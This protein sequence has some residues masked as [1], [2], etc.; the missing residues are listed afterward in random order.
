MVETIEQIAAHEARLLPP[1][2]TPAQLAKAERR[3]RVLHEQ[4]LQD[5]AH[6]QALREAI[7]WNKK[8]LEEGQR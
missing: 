6:L 3:E 7:H 4:I 5:L 8:R 1:T 2:W